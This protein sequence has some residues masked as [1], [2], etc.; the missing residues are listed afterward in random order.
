MLPCLPGE[1]GR[2]VVLKCRRRE[3]VG[4]QPFFTV[5]ILFHTTG[6]A[7]QFVNIATQR[8]RATLFQR[9]AAPPL[10][11]RT[12]EAPEEA[13][14]PE[15][16]D[17]LEALVSPLN[18]IEP[19]RRRREAGVSGGRDL[20]F[21]A[22]RAM[23]QQRSQREESTIQDE[24]MERALAFFEQGG[25]GWKTGYRP[26]DAAWIEGIRDRAD[27]P[28]RHIFERYVILFRM[29]DDVI[30]K[31][32]LYREHPLTGMW[33]RNP[34]LS[35][36]EQVLLLSVRL[37][38]P[39]L[40]SSLFVLMLPRWLVPGSGLGLISTA[41]WVVPLSIILS[42]P[43]MRHLDAGCFRKETLR[44]AHRSPPVLLTVTRWWEMRRSEG[45][46]ISL[47]V[48]FLAVLVSL[49]TSLLWAFEAPQAGDQD[50]EPR[51]TNLPAPAVPPNATQTQTATDVPAPSVS[52]ADGS[53]SL[54]G[55]NAIGPPCVRALLV[56]WAFVWLWE[57]FLCPV[58]KAYMIL[59]ILRGCR[60]GWG[61]I[62]FHDR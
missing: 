32:V 6:E 40:W 7:A 8:R 5:K 24:E 11:Q 4:P 16:I 34:Y 35:T 45:L 42:L 61:E 28:I 13:A 31:R 52:T 49:L 54:S 38:C 10:P 44:A 21:A 25:E 57:L 27:D 43:V 29:E 3:T 14:K 37:V 19:A 46:Y 30:S 51:E 47:C 41:A 1:E 60:G 36:V 26:E 23:R 33:L 2:R 12:E 56:F 9:P 20:A 15:L 62:G 58:F 59:N 22:A 50:Y 53:S 48:L 17:V 18:G 55:D 39:M